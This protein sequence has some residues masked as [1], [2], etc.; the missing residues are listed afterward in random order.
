MG[1]GEFHDYDSYAFYA[2]GIECNAYSNGC[3]VKL[4][5]C[6]RSDVVCGRSA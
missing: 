1:A 6:G 5:C 3:L 4:G 2:S